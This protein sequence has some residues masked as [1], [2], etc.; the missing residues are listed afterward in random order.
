MTQIKQRVY[1]AKGTINVKSEHNA[2]EEQCAAAA[3][4]TNDARLMFFLCGKKIKRL[5]FLSDKAF[6]FP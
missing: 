5:T 3:K 2:K 4:G 6:N 1:K